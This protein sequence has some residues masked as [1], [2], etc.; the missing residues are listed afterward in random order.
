M[1]SLKT[2][3]LL[4]G[5]ALAPA[6]PPLVYLVLM[7]LF[8]GYVEISAHKLQHGILVLLAVSYA[9]NLPVGIPTVWLLSLRQRL[10][11]LHCLAWAAFLGL[12]GGLI[13][14][15]VVVRNPSVPFDP[16]VYVLG[17]GFF[18]IAALITAAAFGLIAGL[19]V[20]S[21]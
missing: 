18:C 16:A 13:F 9:T 19:P 21:R 7:Q 2:V 11:L 6:A 14:A 8:S 15:Y 4:L 17:G 20:R 5:L 3:R 1:A 12:A 10:D